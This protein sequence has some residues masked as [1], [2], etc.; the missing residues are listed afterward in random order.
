MRLSTYR[1]Y[2]SLN[3]TSGSLTTVEIYGNLLDPRITVNP[4][5]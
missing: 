5:A 3:I 4:L 1:Q 2:Q